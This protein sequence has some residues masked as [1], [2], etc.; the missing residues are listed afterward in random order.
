MHP[1]CVGGVG[2][3][4]VW[5]VRGLPG[6]PQRRAPGCWHA[7]LRLLA[8]VAVDGCSCCYQCGGAA[9]CVGASSAAREA[10]KPCRKRFRQ[11]RRCC[12]S[13]LL[14]LPAVRRVLLLSSCVATVALLLS[15]GAGGGEEGL[16]AGGDRPLHAW[17]SASVHAA[18]TG[19]ACMHAARACMQRKQAAHTCTCACTHARACARTHACAQA[20][21]Y[22]CTRAV[23]ACLLQG[24]LLL[25]LWRA[26]GSWG[27]WRA[28]Q[29]R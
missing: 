13:L 2:L 28:R 18:R 9:G 11:A 3:W 15:C 24:H 16:R 26:A 4:R 29:L 8:A 27:G 20:R 10:V 21:T 23:C 25:L 1:G 5:R 14:S 6:A 22:A 17:R 12:C 19:H 7:E